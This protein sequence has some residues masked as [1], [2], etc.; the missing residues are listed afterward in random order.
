M[1]T[2]MLAFAL[3]I[4]LGL[5]IPALP[6]FSMLWVVAASLLLSIFACKRFPLTT[7]YLLGLS[8]CLFHLQNLQGK[9][10]PKTLEQEDIWIKGRVVELPQHGPRSTRLR[11]HTRQLCTAESLDECQWQDW[12]RKLQLNDYEGMNL[13]PGQSW[14]LQ[15]RLKQ[16]HGFANPGTFDYEAWLW[17]QGFNATGYIRRHAG[18]QLL[19][20]ANRFGLHQFRW[21]LR[22]RLLSQSGQQAIPLQ[23]LPLLLA[24][25][26]GDRYRIHSDEWQLFSLAGINHLVVISGLHIGLVAVLAYYLSGW[27]WCRSSVLPLYLPAPRFA[28]LVAILAAAVY[29][30]LAGFSLPTQRAWVMVA[31][32]MWGRLVLREVRPLDSFCL[33]LGLL[34][35]LNPLAPLTSGFWLSF[36]AVGLLLGFAVPHRAEQEDDVSHSS[37][38]TY[39]HSS[40]RAQYVLL[41][42]LSPLLLLHF[43]QLSLIAPLVNLVAIPLV[44]LLVVPLCLLGM[45]LLFISGTLAGMPLRLADL[46][47]DGLMHWL[48][49]MAGWQPGLLLQAPALHW[50]G[51]LITGLAALLLLWRG[52]GRWR[53]LALFGVLPFLWTPDFRPDRGELNLYVLD[54]GQGL[55]LVLVS[56]QQTWIYDTGPAY[57]ERFDAGSGII[58]E[59]LRAHNLGPVDGIIVSHGDSDH[60]GGLPALLQAFPDTELISGEPGR[61]GGGSKPC[62]AGQNQQFDGLQFRFLHPSGPE[63]SGNNASC[64]IRINV[65]GQQLLLTGDIEAGVE[66]QLLQYHSDL[67]AAD[68]VIVPHHGSKSSST[69]AFVE[70]VNPALV[71]NSS[72]Y[73]NRFG[74][75]HSDVVERYDG[76]GAGMFNTAES[77]AVLVRVGSTGDI[78]V[79]EYRKTSPKVWR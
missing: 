50:W 58:L 35:L 22:E 36:G 23:Q 71:I 27:L 79:E 74:H 12:R 60:A 14:Q 66:R 32:F 57:S 9:L 30:G 40:L 16:P 46:L 34:L 39:F 5:G 15:V 17:E 25:G 2:W 8:L 26:I 31:C 33:A 4:C 67:L 72:G 55:A 65:A 41:L 48:Q 21:Q 69:E 43:Q 18:N 53:W 3:G 63:S 56:H 77:G 42:G 7:A 45:C 29:S 75:P 28:A 13:R 38:V 73:L 20:D 59:F 54:V 47:L 11:F 62:R 78:E 37:L 10:L 49:L 51:L 61:I 6:D 68:V 70:A 44:G 76:V 1:R 52:S 24:L 19:A 64:V